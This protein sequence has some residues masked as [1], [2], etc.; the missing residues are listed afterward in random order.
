LGI[1][2]WLE[3]GEHPEQR[4]GSTSIAENPYSI[5]ATDVSQSIIIPIILVQ[6]ALEKH[7][8]VGGV[9]KKKKLRDPYNPARSGQLALPVGLGVGDQA[10]PLSILHKKD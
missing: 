3:K 4:Y 5:Q 7:L 9:L 1:E 8:L 6:S 10:Q 2:L